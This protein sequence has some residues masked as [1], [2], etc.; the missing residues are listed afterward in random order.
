MPFFSIASELL[1]IR[2]VYGL[3]GYVLWRLWRFTVRPLL[4]PNSPRELPYTIP[5][6]LRPCNFPATEPAR[7]TI[8]YHDAME[9]LRDRPE[10][11]NTEH[12]KDLLHGLGCSK[13]GILEI[14][15]N[16]ECNISVPNSKAAHTNRP[17][18]Y[19]VAE[20]L[21][22]KQLLGRSLGN[23]LLARTLE[24]LETQVDHDL[25]KLLFR[26]PKPFARDVYTARTRV[27]RCLREFL[28]L[29]ES[30][31]SGQS[32]AIEGAVAEMRSRGMSE[33]DMAS[34]LLMVFWAINANTFKI[35]FWLI[36]HIVSNPT[37][38]TAVTTE[39]S[40]ILSDSPS[41]E[42]L[43]SLSIRLERN[44]LLEALHHE[45]Q[46][47]ALSTSSARTIKQDVNING[48][49]F[50]SG[51]HAVVPYRYLAM[52]HPL[53]SQEWDAFQPERFLSNPRLGQ[54]KSFLPFGGGKHKC[55]GRFL[56]RRLVLTFT[57][58]FLH[59]FTVR[60]LDGISKM[61]FRPVSSGPASPVG[62]MRLVISQKQY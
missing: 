50:K 11:I 38:L 41:N 16:Q 25:W 54:N 8:V 43:S 28:R 9:V 6:N 48:R 20:G 2:L 30:E 27:Q 29:P 61:G 22:K 46:R 45:A 36:A 13:P 3:V 17:S 4:K 51:T 1:L 44:A 23:D 35:I 57:T 49:I 62:D 42:S 7:L 60:P 18:L 56:S 14:D 5:C 34:Y 53:L 19:K 24:V 39:I 52:R 31:K 37:I 21:M 40:S 59:R 58:L 12:I 47:L 26:I 33:A 10:V 32:W 55:M 15:S